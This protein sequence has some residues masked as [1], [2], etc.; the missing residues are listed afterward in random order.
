MDKENYQ[1]VKSETKFKGEILTL[2]V[3]QVKFPDNKIHEREII[4]HQGAVGI[5]PLTDKGEIIF[6]V[7]YRHPAGEEILEIPAGKL[8]Q[9]GETPLDCAMRELEEETGYKGELVKLA[10]FFTTPGYSNEVFHLYLAKNLEE[11]T[12]EIL[13]KAVLEIKKIPIKKAVSMVSSFEIKDAKTIIGIY[14]AERKGL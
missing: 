12:D 2:L 10:E 6:V 7:Q 1:V 5:V 8:D 3:E 11:V 9:D 4:K 14:L 13:D